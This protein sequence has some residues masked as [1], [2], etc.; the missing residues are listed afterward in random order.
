MN[1]IGEHLTAGYTGR[2]LIW[3]SFLTLLMA[4]IS[5]L[6]SS[7][8]NRINFRSWR[9]YAR[10]F[11]RLHFF[12]IIA[13]L[14]ILFYITI[15]HYFEYNHVWLHSSKNLS[16]FYLLSSLWAG[17]EGS[18]LLWIFFQGLIGV[19]LIRTTKDWEMPVMTVISVSQLFLTSAI[20][21]I[22]I[23]GIKIGSDPFM[24]LR[25]VPDNVANP[26]FSTP[27]Y[28][29]FITDGSGL[30]PL[31]QNFWMKI[32]P[33]FV[34]IGFAASI[35]PFAYAFA[36][37]WKKRYEEWL[38]PAIPWL[39]LSIFGLGTGM[40]MG[41]AWAYEDLTFG[42]FWSWDPVENAALVPL[43]IFIASLHFVLLSKVKNQSFLSTFIVI[44][45]GFLFVLY[46]TFLTRS[47]VLSNTSAH[48]FGKS[49]NLGH[50]AIFLI[51][52]LFAPYILLF[53]NRKKIPKDKNK[54]TF[55]REFW[56]SIGLIIFLLSSFQVIFSTSFPVIN[57]VFGTQM[58][59]PPDR[60]AY[61][62]N[63]QSLFMIVTGIILSVSQLMRSGQDN[64][65]EFLKRILFPIS[66]SL[67]FTFFLICFS[68]I[69]NPLH[70]IFAFTA[71]FIAIS[72]LD[73][74]LRSN[75]SKN[76]SSLISHFGLG[77]FMLGILLS[78][79]QS[80]VISK[81]TLPINMGKYFDDAENMLLPKN[82][83]LPFGNNYIKYTALI[84]D[85]DRL[86][87]QLDFLKKDDD[88]YFKKFT[89]Y[90]SI[91]ISNTKGNVYVP[92]TKH[93]IDR[94]IFTYLLFSEKLDT[95]AYDGYKQTLENVVK[96]ND[97]LCSGDAKF[98]MDTLTVA[99]FNGKKDTNNL[100]VLANIKVVAKEN[101]TYFTS[102][103]FRLENGIVKYNDGELKNISFKVRLEKVSRQAGAF[104]IG[105]YENS[106]D[107]IIIKS[108][109]FPYIIVLWSGA[110]IMLAGFALSI[111]KHSKR[112][113]EEKI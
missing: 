84:K 69:T 61:Y 2:V 113:I 80:K 90:P 63:W 65:K 34:F 23:F 60:E 52:F 30:N 31:L 5:Y 54:K 74:L 55:S 86:Y 41:G 88:K 92:D 16:F 67:I 48:A 39:S 49:G 45:A 99:A 33:P 78:F 7:N 51:I 36:A 59:V 47:G 17:Q 100:V 37:L 112:K 58:F 6:L 43:I 9:F 98:I 85:N 64:I 73:L 81:N 107:I 93:F 1:F 21:G 76:K 70:F 68:D 109:V 102:A 91:I 19:Y 56:M 97:T 3:I 20:L 15:N 24:L 42:G 11:F 106:Q 96:V 66:L 75:L 95:T 103:E 8:E 44:F 82:K 62:N 28:L 87:Y 10:H 108:I 13:V 12:S 110:I 53:I 38:K 72:S 35:V 46:S 26:F 79:A 111:I 27:H 83:I 104:V 32:H 89:L 4:A 57:K 50:L 22:K 25:E 14:V 71:F 40:L 29:K 77:I 94:D 18:F 105:I 101:K